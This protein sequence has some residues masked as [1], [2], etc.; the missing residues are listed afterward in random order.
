MV[1]NASIPRLYFATGKSAETRASAGSCRT[2][3]FCKSAGRTLAYGP[4][5]F[6][7]ASD[8]DS[9]RWHTFVT[10]GS[11]RYD[12]SFV[13]VH[14]WASDAESHME[15]RRAAAM[16]APH[17]DIGSEHHAQRNQKQERREEESDPDAERKEGGEAVQERVQTRVGRLGRAPQQPCMRGLVMRCQRARWLSGYLL[18]LALIECWAR[19]RAPVLAHNH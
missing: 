8:P 15:E 5:L 4:F 14:A 19:N 2:S 7:C 17:T 3:E 18:R 13:L 11:G 9:N 12:V 6:R 10:D 16:T 1:Q